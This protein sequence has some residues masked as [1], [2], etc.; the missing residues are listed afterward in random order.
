VRKSLQLRGVMGGGP[1]A[2]RGVA[3]EGAA[4]GTG[5]GESGERAA[6]GT[7]GVE[8]GERAA[9]GTSELQS[10]ICPVPVCVVG[11]FFFPFRWP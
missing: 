2:G 1:L 9:L 7:G 4:H 5:G 6:P 10:W 8:A 3:R 11:I